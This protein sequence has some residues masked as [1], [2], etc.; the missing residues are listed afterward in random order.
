[1][2][3]LDKLC[4]A[5]PEISARRQTPPTDPRLDERGFCLQPGAVMDLAYRILCIVFVF[6]AIIIELA[7]L[8]LLDIN[9]SP[10]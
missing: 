5:S 3:R 4:V 8:G 9:L 1:M 2:S 6:L 7:V 10:L